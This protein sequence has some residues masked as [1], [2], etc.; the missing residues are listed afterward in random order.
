MKNDAKPLSAVLNQLLETYKL[1]SKVNEVNIV[2]SWEK[3]VGPLIAGRT[4][5][6]YLKNGVLHITISS[7]P[8]KQ[9]LLY[10]KSQ[11]LELLWKE[12]GKGTITDLAI[13]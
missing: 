1:K 4:E 7:A 5:K 9:E 11:I 13:H 6:I 12:F 2:N 10:S 3:V 8:L